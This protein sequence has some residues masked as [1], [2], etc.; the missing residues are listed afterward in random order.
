MIYLGTVYWFDDETGYRHRKELQTEN[1]NDI[2]KLAMIK[3]LSNTLTGYKIT[4]TEG[5]EAEW[6]DRKARS[7]WANGK[8]VQTPTR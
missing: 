3:R 2:L 5:V 4:T 7:K 1:L 6:W 8:E